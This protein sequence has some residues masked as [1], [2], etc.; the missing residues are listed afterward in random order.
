MH[1]CRSALSCCVI[2]G[3]PHDILKKYCVSRDIPSTTIQGDWDGVDDT[4]FSLRSDD[5]TSDDEE[6]GNFSVRAPPNGYVVID[7]DIPNRGALDQM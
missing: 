4:I 7:N 3:L 1:I 2:T 6:M 5:L